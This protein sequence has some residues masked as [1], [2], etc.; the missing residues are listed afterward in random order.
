MELILWHKD[1][2]PS[3]YYAT[4]DGKRI[5][6]ARK[7]G[8]WSWDATPGRTG[9]R[10]CLGRGGI[11]PTA[12]EDLALPEGGASL[13][14]SLHADALHRRLR[15]GVEALERED[16]EMSLEGVTADGRHVFSLYVSDS[17]TTEPDFEEVAV[18]IEAL[19]EAAG[20]DRLPA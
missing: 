19:R 10:N 2:K 12:S 11:S 1:A 4:Q 9:T 13:H 15:H 14:D 17:I 8:T 5:P 16:C 6:T 20:L 18:A 3:S 7:E